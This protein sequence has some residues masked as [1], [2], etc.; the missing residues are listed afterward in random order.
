MRDGTHLGQFRS[1][2]AAARAAVAAAGGATAHYL[3]T[4]RGGLYDGRTCRPGG[5]KNANDAR[6]TGLAANAELLT[7]GCLNVLP[8]SELTPLHRGQSRASRRHSELLWD[9]GAAF[10]QTP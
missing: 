5:A 7:T 1:G 6:G 2:S 4:Y 3:Y 10:W 8:G 9:Y